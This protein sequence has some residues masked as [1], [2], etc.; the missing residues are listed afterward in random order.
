MDAGG[1]AVSGSY[2]LNLSQP[3]MR[4]RLRLSGV[5]INRVLRTLRG[6]LLHHHIKESWSFRTVCSEPDRRVRPDIYIY[7]SLTNTLCYSGKGIGLDR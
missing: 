4:R 6:K 5:H 2:A 3:H 7:G 1:A